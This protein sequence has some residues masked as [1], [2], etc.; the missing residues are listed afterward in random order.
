[1]ATWY[2]A[3]VGEYINVAEYDLRFNKLQ[4]NLLILI[5]VYILT[6]VK[7]KT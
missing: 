2:S 7:A 6:Y 5:R 4:V 3:Q 1:M